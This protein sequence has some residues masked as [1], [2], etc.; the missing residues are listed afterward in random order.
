MLKGLL[1]TL[2]DDGRMRQSDDF[3]RAGSWWRASR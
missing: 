2:A 1:P 3:G